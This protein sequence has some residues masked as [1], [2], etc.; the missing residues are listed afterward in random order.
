MNRPNLSVNGLHVLHGAGGPGRGLLVLH[1]VGQPEGAAAWRPLLDAWPG[2]SVAPDLPGHGGSDP[3]VGA[4]WVPSDLAVTA[5]MVLAGAGLDE[6]VVAGHG[7]GG[8]G[9][10]ILGAAGRAAAVVLIDGL[11]PPWPTHD[12]L[13]AATR[14]W[15]RGMLDDPLVDV[16]VATRPD[17]LVSHGFPPIWARDYV[18][19]LRAAVRVPVLALETPHSPTPSDERDERVAAFG[20]PSS[21]LPV[22]D[23]TPTAV[24]GAMSAQP[25][26]WG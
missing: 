9:A 13:E 18:T 7:W 12:E 16:D 2:P 3:P 17:P 26:W 6:P 25:G 8:H 22:D 1:Q 11:G 23:A 14:D 24:V 20:G 15:L 10:E 19:G 4:K 5:V 21:W